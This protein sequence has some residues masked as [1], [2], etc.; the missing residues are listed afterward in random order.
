MDFWYENEVAI[1]GSE[2]HAEEEDM[3]L[4]A[5]VIRKVWILH[6]KGCKGVLHTQI[7]HR[8][9]MLY[10]TLSGGSYHGN[11]T[12]M[13]FE[14]EWKIKKPAVL[15][16]KSWNTSVSHLH[17]VYVRMVVLQDKEDRVLQALL[18]LISIIKRFVGV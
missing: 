10:P 18:D 9:H 11:G 3:K 4:R 1:K 13:E 8:G 7:F 14:A 5:G 6:P 2:S 15:V 16:I 17:T 12:P